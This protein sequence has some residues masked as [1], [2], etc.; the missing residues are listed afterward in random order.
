MRQPGNLLDKT[1]S[2]SA[3]SRTGKRPVTFTLMKKKCLLQCYR[4]IIGPRFGVINVLS[5]TPT[6][7]SRSPSLGK[8]TSCNKVIM[9]CLQSLFWLSAAYNFELMPRF[10]PGVF[11]IAADAASRLHLPGYL[12]TLLPFTCLSPLTLHMSSTTLMFLICIVLL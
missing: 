12:E 2:I 10:I 11:N 6:M 3:G 4:P 5:F 8:G 7:Q 1:G 9:K